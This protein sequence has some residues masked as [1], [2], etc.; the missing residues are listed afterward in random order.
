MY[1]IL[2][3]LVIAGHLFTVPGNSR[4]QYGEQCEKHLHH[5]FQSVVGKKKDAHLV[6]VSCK[7]MEGEARI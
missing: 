7:I 4:F 3:T 2:Y 6:S 5:A 1:A